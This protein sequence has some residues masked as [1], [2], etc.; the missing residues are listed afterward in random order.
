MPELSLMCSAQ[1]LTGFLKKSTHEDAYG[2]SAELKIGMLVEVAVTAIV[3]RRLAHV[4]TEPTVVAGS[5]VKDWDGLDI[6]EHHVSCLFTVYSWSM[7]GSSC[8]L[9]HY[10]RQATAHLQFVAFKT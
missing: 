9:L 8:D 5:V 1:G 7:H 10:W 6:G 2:N 4:T 3:D